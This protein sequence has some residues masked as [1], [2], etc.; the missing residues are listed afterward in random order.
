MRFSVGIDGVEGVVQALN[1]LLTQFA[2]LRQ[3]QGDVS[4]S[5]DKIEAALLGAAQRIAGTGAA[6]REGGQDTR[7][8]AEGF[9]DLVAQ[10]EKFIQVQREAAQLNVVNGSL[11]GKNRGELETYSTQALREYIAIDDARGQNAVSVSRDIVRSREKEAAALEK[12]RAEQDRLYND[13]LSS[14]AKGKDAKATEQDR[15]YN[16]YLTHQYNA[17]KKVRTEQERL[18][19]DYLSSQEQGIAKQRAAQ[20]KLYNEYLD[21]Q[22]RGI[23]ATNQ[24]TT[25]LVTQRYALYDVGTTT[26]AVSVATL[27]L[28]AAYEA[29][30]VSRQRAFTDVA[31]T[32]GIGEDD[33]ELGVL[34]ERLR[35]LTRDMPEAYEHLASVAKQGGQ[36]GIDDPQALAT[37][38]NAIGKFSAVTDLDPSA[39]TE[40][41]GKLVNILHLGADG[42]DRLASSI[43][44]AGVRSA[45]TE[46][47]I[48]KVASEIG[49]YATQVGFAAE[50][51]VGLATAYASLQIPGERA[52]GVTNDLFS[53]IGKA[54]RGGGADL[55]NFA[56]ISGMSAEEFA[57]GWRTAASETTLAFIKGLGATG[58]ITGALN[59]LGLEGQRVTPTLISLAQN[60]DLVTKSFNE[61]REGSTNGFMD[62]SAAQKF[63]TAAAKLQ[64]L[65]NAIGEIAEASGD[66]NL[67]PFMMM[68]DLLTKM[69][70]NAA[71]FLRTDFGQ[72]V[73]FVGTVLLVLVGGMAAVVSAGAIWLASLYAIR[74]ALTG[75]DGQLTGFN[76]RLA[77]TVERLI[78]VS[79]TA[80]ITSRSLA[81][82]R[83]GGEGAATGLSAAGVGAT[84]FSKAL[85]AIPIIGTVLLVADLAASLLDLNGAF[86]DG[87]AKAEDYF[88]SLDGLSDAIRADNASKFASSVKDANDAIGNNSGQVDSWADVL[89]RAIDAQKQVDAATSGAA[90]AIDVQTLRIGENTE[91]WLRNQLVQSDSF[92][93]IFEN[94]D[95]LQKLTGDNKF[96]AFGTEVDFEA[97]DL[98]K[99]IELASTKGYDAA[100]AYMDSWRTG[101]ALEFAKAGDTSGEAVVSEAIGGEDV[102][103]KADEAGRAIG[104]AVSSGMK[105]AA[106]SD[107][108]NAIVDALYPIAEE[109]D[110]VFEGA[111]T[112]VQQYLDQVYGAVNAQYALANSL[113]A[114]GAEFYNNGAESAANSQALQQVIS[115]IYTAAGGGPQAAANMKA[116]F[117]MLVQGGYASAQQLIGLTRVIGL[118]GGGSGAVLPKANVD[119]SAFQYGLEDASVSATNMG[120]SVAAA[121]EEVRTLTDYASDLGGVMDR[122]F[123]I[124]FG[125]GQA[126]DDI[127]SGWQKIAKANAD[128]AEAIADYRVELQK[129]SSDKGDLEFWLAVAENYGDTARAKEIRADLAEVNNKIGDTEKKLAEERAKNSKSLTGNSEAAIENRASLLD[130]MGSYQDLLEQYAANGMSQED[131][132]RKAAELKEEFIRQATQMGYNRDEVLRFAASFDDMT[133]AIER[134][135]RNITVDANVN[136][137][138]QALAEFEAQAKKSAR[139]AA[140]SIAN[141]GGLGWK[142]PKIPPAIVP[143][144]YKLP[145]YDE[146]MRMQAA[147]RQNLNDPSFHIGLGAGGQGGQVF[148]YA[149]GGYTGDGWWSQAAGV[150][151]KREFVFD[152]PSTA[153]WGPSTLGSMMSADGAT[154]AL[155]KAILGG[156][157]AS[158]PAMAGG[159][160]P[161]SLGSYERQLLERIAARV[162][163]TISGN[164]IAR[165]AGAGAVTNDRTGGS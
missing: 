100:K 91:Q 124:R 55:Q 86:D 127:A 133:L 46:G 94:L 96:E 129:L 68:L 45:A 10:M 89:Q 63:D 62:E 81:S 48:M 148:G 16:D 59:V 147:I 36:L 65:A 102:L 44:F 118:L 99:Y 49:P 151:H 162:G 4:A 161:T 39:V 164:T 50:E 9:G 72:G 61:A 51:T 5:G 40:D 155:V 73:A 32:T 20:D 141:G 143:V 60:A 92:K 41:M 139:N 138:L 131:L 30:A 34:R 119:L 29:V 27:G 145:S 112:G 3:A 126:L 2:Q 85:K 31:R 28:V 117:D 79:A 97:F 26:A 25:S 154:I 157:K 113:S 82:V 130:L 165:M 121:A 8:Y 149:D 75:L 108:M 160:G 69:A 23:E 77:Q 87:S 136:P 90:D 11:D 135:P 35:L 150:V 152:A 125:A 56:S 78:G 70:Q 64:F 103:R 15:L 105:E 74:T 101:L 47:Q 109:S 6:M 58:D 24:H 43:A 42:Y 116:L 158:A 146:L 71:D 19:N 17:E 128:A 76:F 156:G 22:R 93:A 21:H 110:A 142:A 52:R 132:K 33:P 106:Q 123:D 88:G 14:Q 54:V 38:T 13:Y 159:G 114:L 98:E 122:A 107:A 66:S 120:G 7:K 95:A 80:R 83:T 18:Y 53:T 140:S 1:D 67:E 104:S 111:A 12:L 153:A 163:V 144:A 57:N 84:I 115:D 134:V 137:A 37:F